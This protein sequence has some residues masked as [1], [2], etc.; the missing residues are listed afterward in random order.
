[1][2]L[3]SIR[4]SIISE[5]QS[6]A[7]A[8]EEEGNAQARRIVKEAEDKAKAILK[9]MQEQADHEADRLA[10]ESEAGAETEAN[11]M[12]L[13]AKGQAVERSLRKV[14]DGAQ[15]SISKNAM[16]EI[17]KES[18]KQFKELSGG[19]FTIKTSKKNEAMFKGTAYEVEYSDIDGFMLYADHGKIAL[20]ATVSSVVQHRTDEARKIIAS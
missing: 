8:I 13:E 18:I 1:M 3:D 14:L 5:A 9:D 7:S 15:T 17:L 10:K 16:K 2:S 20:N 6:K 12:L 4:K 11:S 19:N